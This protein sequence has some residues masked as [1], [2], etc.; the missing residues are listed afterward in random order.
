MGMQFCD[1]IKL[2]F[3]GK[4]KRVWLKKAQ[5]IRNVVQGRIHIKMTDNQEIT[6][7]NL[8]A[9]KKPSCQFHQHLKIVPCRFE[10]I[11]TNAVY[12]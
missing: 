8:N 3:T 9:E 12:D 2:A 1:N 7:W 5:N 11:T 10:K 6:N 4:V